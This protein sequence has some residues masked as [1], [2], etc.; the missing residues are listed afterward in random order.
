MSDLQPLEIHFHLV[1]GETSRFAVDD[2]AVAG[3]LLADIHPHRVFT[4]AE[5]V[6]GGG[7][8]MTVI[9][10]AAISR[11]DLIVEAYPKWPFPNNIRDI[12][13]ITHAMFEQRRS[14]IVADT[15]RAERIV[16]SGTPA[17]GCLELDL[18]GADKVYAEVHLISAPQT[19]VER[20]L[21]I[22][23]MLQNTHV[24]AMRR[25]G[26][27]AVLVNPANLARRTPGAHAA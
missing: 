20:G 25:H 3:A 23:Q 21:A 7:Y 19:P 22:H 13:Q 5:I 12:S 17:V 27:G 15:P 18:L 9:R 1:N 14:E 26:G 24:V 8:S 11:I 2:P 6:I 4:P 16:P 10:T